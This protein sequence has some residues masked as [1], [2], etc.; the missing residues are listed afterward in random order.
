MDVFAQTIN[1][2]STTP[3]ILNRLDTELDMVS[4][5]LAVISSATDDH[6]GERRVNTRSLFISSFVAG[7]YLSSAQS[8]VNEL[9]ERTARSAVA[10][11]D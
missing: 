7:D 5:L 11:A 10:P 6:S 3:D 1:P 8:L 4:E 2:E 9:H